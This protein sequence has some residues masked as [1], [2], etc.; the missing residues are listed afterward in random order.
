[1]R[2]M[3]CGNCG[4]PLTEEMKFCRACGTAAGA[5]PAQP[6]RE[7]YS[8][9][10]YS[11]KINDP[12]FAKY[13]K[14][15]TRWSAIF[16]LILALAAVIGF[17]I[18]G[19]SGGE[20]ENPQSLYIGLG[21]GGMFILIALFQ[22][23]GRKRSKTWDG[24]VV[25]KKVEKKR[26]QERY[27][28]DDHYWQNYI[29]YTVLIREQNGKK[30]E[31]RTEDDDTVYNYYRIGDHLRHHAGLNSYEKYDKSKDSII[32]CNACATLNDIGDDYC[33]RC[34]CPLLK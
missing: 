1:M 20:M 10:G 25:D 16:S 17:A 5:A 28:N 27:G 34:K 33:A 9:I 19:E 24:V 3:Y 2:N 23:L 13:L 12:A 15:A 11:H 26:R 32:F 6:T 4:A 18:A 29:L 30:H 22:I 8:L 31:I 21:I 14:N 7:N